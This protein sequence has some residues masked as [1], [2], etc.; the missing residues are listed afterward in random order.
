VLPQYHPQSCRH[1]LHIITQ[2]L[3]MKSPYDGVVAVYPHTPVSNRCHERRDKAFDEAVSSRINECYPIVAKY[4]VGLAADTSPSGTNRA[5]SITK[6]GSRGVWR[7]QADSGGTT[8][9]PPSTINNSPMRFLRSSPQHSTRFQVT[10]L[11]EFM[12]TS[13]TRT[14]RWKPP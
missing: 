4:T 1:S 6:D 2:K 13:Q 8:T 5:M 7:D 3:V 9:R 12:S 10:I 11:P 14:R